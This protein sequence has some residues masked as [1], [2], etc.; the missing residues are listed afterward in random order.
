MVLHEYTLRLL[1]TVVLLLLF[2]LVVVPKMIANLSEKLNQA[3]T[4]EVVRGR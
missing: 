1:L 3:V 4:P 2:G